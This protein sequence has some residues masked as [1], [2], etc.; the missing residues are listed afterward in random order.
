VV[1]KTG[2]KDV[3]TNGSTL[4]FSTVKMDK[5][6]E[7]NTDNYYSGGRYQS[8]VFDSPQRGASSSSSSSA[9]YQQSVSTSQSH[10]QQ[11]YRNR[12]YFNTRGVAPTL[13]PPL[14]DGLYFKGEVVGGG[15][16]TGGGGGGGD[17]NSSVEKR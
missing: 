4:T 1:T 17:L 16:A 11:D 12:P 5:E 10:Q 6:D 3:K 14:Y 9:Y 15:A 13:P 7:N 8:T 2:E